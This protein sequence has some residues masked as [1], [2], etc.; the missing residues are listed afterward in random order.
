MAEGVIFNIFKSDSVWCL[1]I[2]VF[3]LKISLQSF[4]EIIVLDAESIV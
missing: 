3:Q 4:K 2:I 1:T